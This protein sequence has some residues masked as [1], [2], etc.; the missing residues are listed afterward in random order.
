MRKSARPGWMMLALLVAACARTPGPDAAPVPAPDAAGTP[1]PAAVPLR[2]PQVSVREEGGDSVQRWEPPAVDLAGRAPATVRR[3]ARQALARDALF[4]G[5]ETAIPL[6]LAL[7]RRDPGD[8]V[9]ARGLEQAVRRVVERGNAHLEQA[10]TAADGDEAALADAA[11]EALVALSV[12]PDDPAT[13]RLQR[14]V[15]LAQRVDG[16]VRDGEAELGAGH[17]EGEGAAAAFAEALQLAPDDPRARQGRAA[18]ESALIARAEAAAQAEDFEQAATWL[19]RA[20]D[21][22]PP[23]PAVADARLRVQAVRRARVAALNEAAVHAL[24]APTGLRAAQDGLAHALRIAE[25][26]DP[27]AARLQ[28]RVDRALRYG[29]FRAGQVFTDALADGSRGPQMVVVPYGAFVMGAGADEDDAADAERPAHYVRFERGFAMSITEVTVAEFARYVA[30]S[31]AR[32]RATRRGHSV[33]YDVRSGNFVR[34]SGADWRSGYDGHPAAPGD[35]VMHV[36]VRDAEAYARWLSEQTGRHYRLPSESE[37][38]YALRAGQAG[39]YAWGDAATPPPASGNYTGALDV[40]PSGRH[41]DNAFPGYGDGYWGPSPAGR[42]AANAWGLRDMAGN[43]SEWVADC[44]H[45]S[46]RRA[47]ADGAAWYNP[48]CRQRVVRGGG[49]S[50]S[51][52]QTRAAWRMSQDSDV[53]SARIGFRLV[54]GI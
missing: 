37:F 39:R 4:D 33:V 12:A 28:A 31:G 42:F 1:A 54:R 8:G 50:T 29:A 38:E 18:V 6:Y 44:W 23:S 22:R 19:A 16:L 20:D 41:W 49:W 30:A 3:Q 14:Q 2:R 52:E 25:P 17:V 9:A 34:S 32:P 13:R 45:A 53:T 11:R 15:E 27:V 40:S 36:S 43:L 35:P 24:L 7:L 26:G 21:V 51:P 47:P 10:Q 5:P 48:G 46:Y